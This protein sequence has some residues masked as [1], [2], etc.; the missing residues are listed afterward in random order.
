MAD[1]ATKALSKE[2]Q[3]STT[4]QMQAN[5]AKLDCYAREER[6]SISSIFGGIQ[7]PFLEDLEASLTSQEDE[8]GKSEGRIQR[9]VEIAGQCR[10]LD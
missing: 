7:D 9:L 6:R 4:M 2:T 10:D 8:E 5:L 1:V 3:P